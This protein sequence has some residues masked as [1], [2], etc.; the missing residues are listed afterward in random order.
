MVKTMTKKEK[1]RF[2]AILDDYIEHLT[3]NPDS[4]IN[5]V[6]GILSVTTDFTPV[7]VMIM[8]NCC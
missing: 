4:L 8:Q 2:L 1:N 3:R 7:D 6:F 5:R